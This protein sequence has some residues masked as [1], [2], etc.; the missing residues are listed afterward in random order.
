MKS[1]T[2]SSTPPFVHPAFSSVIPVAQLTRIRNGQRVVL[3][4]VHTQNLLTGMADCQRWYDEQGLGLPW[5]D[6][7]YTGE[8]RIGIG[9]KRVYTLTEAKPGPVL[10][11]M[12]PRPKKNTYTCPN[13]GS[14]VP[15]T[16]FVCQDCGRDVS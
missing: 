7:A 5:R 10:G 16:S 2:T 4:T 1:Q 3:H 12:F 6:A 9:F 13:C 15:K 8:F 11:Y 14:E